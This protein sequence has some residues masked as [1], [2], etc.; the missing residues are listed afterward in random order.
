MRG[1]NQV[2]FINKIDCS[3]DVNEMVDAEPLHGQLWNYPN[4]WAK[5]VSR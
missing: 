4:S 3:K 2:Y 1:K 5:L